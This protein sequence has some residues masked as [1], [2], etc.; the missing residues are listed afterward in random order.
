[1]ARRVAIVKLLARMDPPVEDPEGALADQR[2]LVDGA[3]VTNPAS[4]VLPSARV[5]VKPPRRPRGAQKLGAALDRFGVA[6]AGRVGLDLGACTGGFT[7]A[8]LDRGAAR[9]FAVDV[10][11]GQLL[12][13]L[14]QDPRVVSLERTNVADVTPG[15]LGTLP[16]V[17]VVDV[18]KLSL[19]EV[20]RQLADHEVP[21]SGTE[22]VGLVKPLFELGI[23]ELPEGEELARAL[24]LAEAG[25]VD[26]GWE[27]LGS[28][29]SPMR[30]HRGAVEFFVH[31]RWPD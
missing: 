15:L 29:E 3:V 19:R 22:L 8:L 10:G 9:V 18:T 14:R 11:F 2:V 20:V 23:G 31:A 28:M 12:G 17:V 4:Q 6:V 30:G 7:Q 5:V 13:S 26:A 27:H 21:G 16:G 24:R 1:M 25:L